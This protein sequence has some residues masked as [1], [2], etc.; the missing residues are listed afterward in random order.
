MAKYDNSRSKAVAGERGREANPTSGQPGIGK[1]TL[2]QLSFG[3][4]APAP[5]K[6]GDRTLTEQL[7]PIQRRVGSDVAGRRHQRHRQAAVP[8]CRPMFAR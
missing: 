3:P 8:R 4:G 7:V 2:V 5:A 1:Q 6:P